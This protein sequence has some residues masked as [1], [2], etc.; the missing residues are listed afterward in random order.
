[1]RK[2]QLTA[3]RHPPSSVS[4]TTRCTSRSDVR[5]T[6]AP[7][8]ESIQIANPLAIRNPDL[9]LSRTRSIKRLAETSNTHEPNASAVEARLIHARML[10]QSK[11][12]AAMFS[13]S[14]MLAVFIETRPRSAS[15]KVAGGGFGRNGS[16]G[17]VN[18]N[19]NDN[20]NH[21]SHDS[22]ND[23]VDND[24]HELGASH[25][26]G[27]V[28]GVGR[29]GDGIRDGNR[30]GAQVPSVRLGCEWRSD[31]VRSNPIASWYGVRHNR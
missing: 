14:L 29:D 19:D 27:C 1:M 17:D 11:H 12:P 30:D 5:Y 26:Y 20:D 2:P 22:A 13:A 24:K 31:P 23:D 8:A 28:V 21:D 10:Q 15:L 7:V 6:L 25:S 9:Y 18:E 3:W 4:E 16:G